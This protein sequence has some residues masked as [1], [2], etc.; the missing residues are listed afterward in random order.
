MHSDLHEVYVNSLVYLYRT[1][2]VRSDQLLVFNVSNDML[3]MLYE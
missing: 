3:M 1:Q 2:I